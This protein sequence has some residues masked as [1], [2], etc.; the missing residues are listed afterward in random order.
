MEKLSGLVITKDNERTIEACIASIS[1]LVDELII[2]D[3]HSKDGT[4]EIIRKIRPDAIIITRTLDRFD[5]QRN[6]CLEIAKNPWVLMID[7]DEIIEADLATAISSL[8]SLE[9]NQEI[10]AYWTIRRNRF[11]DTYLNEKY[12]DRPLLFRQNLRFSRPVHEII[13]LDQ[14]KTKKLNGYLRHEGWVSIAQ[15]MEKMNRYS[16]LMA[17]KWLE[18][19]RNYS[20][21]LLTIFA[22]ILP[23]R[24]FFICFFGKRFYKAGLWRNLSGGWPLYS[25]IRKRKKRTN[26]LFS[27]IKRLVT[28]RN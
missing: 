3:D 26:P 27:F 11:F 2:I 17:D 20:R 10:D 9:E 12:R 1:P 8:H 13:T 19:K 16:S 18:Q 25:N 5:A 22:F 7:S 21:F 4:L 28:G 14:K 24:Y 15:N 6:T 23:L